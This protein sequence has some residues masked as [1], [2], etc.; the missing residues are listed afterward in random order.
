MTKK[1]NILNNY[2]DSVMKPIRIHFGNDGYINIFEYN[3][4]TELMM[5]QMLE[6]EGYDVDKEMIPDEARKAMDDGINMLIRKYRLK[7]VSK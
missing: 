7:K 4:A 2:V 3:T 6:R 1:D 5:L